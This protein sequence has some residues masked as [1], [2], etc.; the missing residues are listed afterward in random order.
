MYPQFENC[1]ILE[2]GYDGISGKK[3]CIVYNNEE[4]MLKFPSKI[5]KNYSNTPICEYASS[6]IYSTLGFKTHKT[7]LGSYK[8][9]TV[10]ACRDFTQDGYRLTKFS[11]M[12]NQ[13][14][15]DDTYYKDKNI[16]M[17]RDIN[18]IMKNIREIINYDYLKKI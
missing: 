9:K 18:F 7:I 16:I 1:K 6:H 4:Y 15:N 2:K 14:I 3:I 11:E 12:I 5:Q 13:N 8:N 10:V 17:D